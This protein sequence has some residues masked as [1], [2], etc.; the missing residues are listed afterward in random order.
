MY[1]YFLRRLLWI[2]PVLFLV[3]I[4][5]FGIMRATPGGPWSREK[6]LPASIMANLDKKYHLD[7]PIWQQ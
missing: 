1:Q 3:S 6:R 4:I 5:T 7:W 2:I